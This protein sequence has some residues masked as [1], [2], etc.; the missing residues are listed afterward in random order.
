[1]TKTQTGT[2]LRVLN[3]N[4]IM[5]D[6]AGDRVILLGRG[7]GFGKRLGDAV[8][9]DAAT[10]SFSPS[11]ALELRQLADFAREIPLEVFR[12]ARRA[13]DHAETAGDVR[14]SQALLLSVADHLHFAVV[15]AQTGLRVD[16]P[17]KWEIAQLYPR[18]TELGKATVRFANEELGEASAIDGDE[19]T[20]FAMHFV[21]AQFAK[22]DT[23]QTVAMTKTLQS[24]VDVVTETLGA[25]AT[26]DPTNVARFITHLRYL[27][28]RMTT[29]TQLESA[30][31]QLF[32]AIRD[33][34]PEIVATSDRVRELIE[35]QGGELS[36]AEVCYLEI[37]LARLSTSGR[38]PQA[39]PAADG[40]AAGE[41][42]PS[43]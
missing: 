24:V 27:Y 6:A 30:P 34:Y 29:R 38:E 41:D 13:V 28:A 9:L 35:A 1:M 15:R 33:S 22:S 43:S 23:S 39:A 32:T 11:T 42:A 18:E 17:L 2:L 16:F 26:A 20:A 8:D 40:E 14:P 31:P 3:N 36:E 7:I 12:V 25:D 10:E 21:N 4:A 19:A 37:H 5:V